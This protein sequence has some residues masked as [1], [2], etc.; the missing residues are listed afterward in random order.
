MGKKE[1]APGTVAVIDPDTAPDFVDYLNKNYFDHEADRRRWMF[2]Y[3]VNVDY[4]WINT[5]NFIESF[6]HALKKYFFKDKQQRRIDT[7]IFILIH[8]TLPHYQQVWI[9]HVVKVGRMTAG[10]K[11]ALRMANVARHFMSLERAR[12]PMVQLHFQPADTNLYNVRSFT[13]SSIFYSLAVDWEDA[14][15]GRFCSCSCPYFKMNK[16][17]CKHIA[18][19][20]I[21]VQGTTFR[22]D[23]HWRQRDPAEGMDIDDGGVDVEGKPRIPILSGM[24]EAK[25]YILTLFDRLHLVDE[26]HGITNE[27]E[28]VDAIKRAAD[29]FSIHSQLKPEHSLSK[30]RTFQRSR[31]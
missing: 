7:V 31:A 15:G 6:H 9:R 10:R 17:C 1:V 2:C 24:Q 21:E 30:K 19:A 27:Q 4:A 26:D 18:L 29:L 25:H 20:L 5:N 23:G 14:S 12:N 8:R 3:R 11:Q 28:V 22:Y 13:D 16:M